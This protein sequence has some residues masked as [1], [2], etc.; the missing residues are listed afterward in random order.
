MGDAMESGEQKRRE[1]PIAT[2]RLHGL[3]RASWHHY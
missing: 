3:G 2:A 1:R